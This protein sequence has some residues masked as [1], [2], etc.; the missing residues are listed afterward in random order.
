M[1]G[2]APCCSGLLGVARRLYRVIIYWDYKHTVNPRISPQGL[3]C[4]TGGLFQSLA[5]PSKVDVKNDIIYS[6]NSI[7]SF[8]LQKLISSKELQNVV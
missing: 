3:I 5:F 6:I 7:L 2:E 4:K 1:L 8:Y